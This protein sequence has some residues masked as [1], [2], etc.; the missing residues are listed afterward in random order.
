[1]RIARRL[2]LEYDGVL[3]TDVEALIYSSTFA[4]SLSAIVGRFRKGWP[5]DLPRVCNQQTDGDLH[6]RLGNGAE[7]A[8]A[9]SLIACFQKTKQQIENINL[10]FVRSVSDSNDFVPTTPTQPAVREILTQLK[11]SSVLDL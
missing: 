11:P 1:E 2:L 3:R 5:K 6:L 9:N 8:A 7:A 10:P 4:L